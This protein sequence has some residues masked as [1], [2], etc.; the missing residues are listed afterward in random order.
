LTGNQEEDGSGMALSDATYPSLVNQS[1]FDD[2]DGDENDSLGQQQQH[3]SLAG[4][5]FER[6]LL[7]EDERNVGWLLSEFDPDN[8]QKDMLLLKGITGFKEAGESAVQI[9]PA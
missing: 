5:Y 3:N 9:N 1:G 8:D 2:S 6:F 7:N 4:S